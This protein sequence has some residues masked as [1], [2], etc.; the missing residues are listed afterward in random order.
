MIS[1]TSSSAS[2]V[3]TRRAIGATAA[4]VSTIL[5]GDNSRF[6][7]NIVQKG[8]CLRAG[9]YHLD[10][11][12]SGCMILY[13]T[14]QPDSVEKVVEA[15]RFEANRICA[16]GVQEHEVARVKNKR[17]TSL[18]VESEAPYHRLNQL[19]DDMECRGKPRTVDEML[20]DVDA[21]SVD[22]VRDYLRACPLN[23]EGHLTSVGARLWPNGK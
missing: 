19:M 2:T 22:S 20:A 23:G 7:W 10:Y 17:R 3:S 6:Y 5:G 15:L 14:C 12:D 13:G 8:L 9:A 11:T 4:A 1:P 21:V 18:A 16:E